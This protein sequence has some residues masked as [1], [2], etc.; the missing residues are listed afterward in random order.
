M[1]G[2]A[3]LCAALALCAPAFAASA[4][5]RCLGKPATIVARGVV[6]GTAHADVIVTGPGADRI[7]AGGGNDRICS[8][9]GD[10]VI[11]GAVGSDRIDAGAGDDEVIG[12]NGSDFVLGGPGQDSVFGER[13]N[14][15]LLGGPGARDFLD[16]GLGDDSL[17][18]GPGGFDQVI[19]GVGNDKLSGGDGEGDLLRPDFGRDTVDGGA[20]THDTVSFAVSGQNSVVFGV[21]GVV[22]DLAAGTVEGDGTDTVAGVEDVV[23]TAFGDVI[24][25]DAGPNIL[26]GGGGIDDLT[27]VGAGDVAHGGIGQDRCRGFEAQDSCE[28]PGT[29]PYSATSEATFLELVQTGGVPPVGAHSVLEVDLAGGAAA[30]SLTA[31][32]TRPNF[33][34]EKPGVD[35]LVSFAEGAWLLTAHNIELGLGDGCEALSPETARCPLSGTPEAV[36]VSGST[37]DDTLRIDPAAPATIGASINGFQGTDLIEGGAGDDSLDGYLSGVTT[38]VIRGGPGDDALID[39]AA[40]EGGSGSDLL[41][42]YPCSSE[43][44]SGGAGIDSVSF[45]RSSNGVEAEIGGIAG[46]AGEPGGLDPGCPAIPGFAPTFID[47]SIESIEGSPNDDILRGDAERNILLGRGG[48]DTV[49]GGGGDDFLV[50]GLGRD[51]LFGEGGDDRL[52]SRDEARDAALDCGPG[53]LG[54]VASA[55]RVDPVARHCRELGG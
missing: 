13:G 15:Q 6:K 20:G 26:Y 47:E 11:E 19:G 49:Y 48:D 41:I 30:G 45:A 52:Y 54:D 39:G 12:G 3:S 42:A 53:G 28:L 34:R 24:S 8:G 32:V 55:D 43:A 16:S 35:I 18:G 50:G 4:P 36:L 27:G 5:P 29:T 51:G 37:G 2:A 33:Y 17:D 7:D 1:S 9:G 23:G 44:I 38:D 22:V 46:F 14:D 40:L 21:G 10:D 25:G 31:V